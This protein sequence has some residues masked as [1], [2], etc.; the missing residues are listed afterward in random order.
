MA[1]HTIA[2]CVKIFNMFYLKSSA[3]YFRPQKDLYLSILV[4]NI[5]LKKI[6]KEIP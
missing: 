6:Y 2:L 3:Q 1:K 5:N 4:S